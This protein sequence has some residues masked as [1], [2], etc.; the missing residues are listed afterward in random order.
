MPTD[1]R[2]RQLEAAHERAR[3]TEAQETAAALKRTL[4]PGTTK[5]VEAEASQIEAA[6]TLELTALTDQYRLD[7]AALATAHDEI[8]AA[9]EALIDALRQGA[10]VRGK[11][12]RG[13]DAIRAH[14]DQDVLVAEAVHGAGSPEGTAARQHRD[15]LLGPGGLPVLMPRMEHRLA[16]EHVAN[17]RAFRRASR[18]VT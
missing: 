16:G 2:D 11:A 18:L 5:K 10:Y 4:A 14:L 13:I 7:N 1:L 15:E 3:I 6:L 17:Q 12:R 9:R 8:L